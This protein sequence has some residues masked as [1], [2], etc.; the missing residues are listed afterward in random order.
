VG[1]RPSI[2]RSIGSY[3]NPASN[4]GFLQH[5]AKFFDFSILVSSLCHISILPIHANENET[6]HTKC[7]KNG[8]KNIIYLQPVLIDSPPGQVGGQSG[9]QNQS[10]TSH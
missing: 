9:H 5:N 1:D 4:F 8:T 3:A 6:R 10:L 2:D 7:A